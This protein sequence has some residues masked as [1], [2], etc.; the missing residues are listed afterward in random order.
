MNKPECEVV[1]DKLLEWKAV[2]VACLNKVRK[3]LKTDP[4]RFL[5]DFIKSPIKDLLKAR[6]LVSEEMWSGYKLLQINGLPEQEIFYVARRVMVQ[7]FKDR[8]PRKSNETLSNPAQGV[9]LQA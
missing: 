9:A 3:E 5:A 6:A 1:L 8:Y 4:A 7:W 2:P